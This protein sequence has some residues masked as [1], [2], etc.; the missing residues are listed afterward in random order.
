[1]IVDFYFAFKFDKEHSQNIQH[2]LYSSSTVCSA[3]WIAQEYFNDWATNLNHLELQQF[4]YIWWYPNTEYKLYNVAKYMILFWYYTNF[5]S[6][7]RQNKILGCMFFHIKL[8]QKMDIF[9]EI[10]RLP[11]F[12]HLVLS[13]WRDVSHRW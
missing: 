5:S 12:F 10:A 6:K 1:M 13:S 11:K 4:I 3:L 9:I 2:F 7:S 8:N